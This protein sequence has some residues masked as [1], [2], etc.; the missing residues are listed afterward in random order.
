MSLRPAE[1]KEKRRR[2]SDLRAPPADGEGQKV[3][4]PRDKEGKEGPGQE[5]GQD[6]GQGDG[7][8]GLE[9]GGA[10]RAGW[11]SKS[12]SKRAK[13]AAMINVM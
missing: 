5:A 9:R 11:A 4:R 1:A 2:G 8:E 6:C 7:T 3:L 13:T 10:K 12:V